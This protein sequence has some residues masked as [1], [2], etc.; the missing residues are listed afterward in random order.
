MHAHRLNAYEIAPAGMKTLQAVEA[1]LH[2]TTLGPQLIELVK[3]RAS[4]INDAPIALT[5]TARCCAKVARP[6]GASTS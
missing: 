5:R 2:Q 1:Y 6:S 3:M 4:Q